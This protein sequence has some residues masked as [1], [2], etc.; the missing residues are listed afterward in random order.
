MAE[1]NPWSQSGVLYRVKLM[2]GQWEEY[3]DYAS[4][5]VCRYAI[6]NINKTPTILSV[7]GKDGN[8]YAFLTKKD[9]T[10]GKRYQNLKTE[11]EGHSVVSNVFWSK[12]CLA[13]VAEMHLR[14]IT[15]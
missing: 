4:E 15:E 9:C 5:N 3:T 11:C 10:C 8:V 1:Y 2:S 14:V 13:R 12:I 7:E 6:I